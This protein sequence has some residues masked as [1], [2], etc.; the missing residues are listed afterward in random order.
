MIQARAMRAFLFEPLLSRLVRSG[1]LRGETKKPP[2]IS[3][4]T[5]SNK[6][7]L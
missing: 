6:K 4:A 1:E 7:R 5:A 2:L 3:L